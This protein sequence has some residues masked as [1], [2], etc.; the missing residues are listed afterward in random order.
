MVLRLLLRYVLLSPTSAGPVVH[1]FS[2]LETVTPNAAAARNIGLSIFLAVPISADSF[3][4]PGE[5]SIWQCG[6]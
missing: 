1:D 2:I 3:F 4:L 6:S 5:G